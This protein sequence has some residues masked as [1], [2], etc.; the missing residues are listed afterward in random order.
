MSKLCHGL[1][2]MYLTIAVAPIPLVEKLKELS[3]RGHCGLIGN[4]SPG[5]FLSFRSRHNRLRPLG[6]I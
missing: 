4:E 6:R 3:Q 2:G 1:A 5:L